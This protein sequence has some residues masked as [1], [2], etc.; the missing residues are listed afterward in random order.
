MNISHELHQAFKN[1]QFFEDGHIYVDTDTGEKLPSVTKWIQQF[2]PG[3][4]KEYWLGVKA[5]EA[6]ITPEELDKQW[7]HKSLVGTRQGSLLHDYVLHRLHRRT[8]KQQIPAFIDKDTYRILL[9]QAEEYCN[10]VDMPILAL[11]FVMGDSSIPLA[12]MSDAIHDLGNNKL[13]I[14]DLKTGQLKKAYGKHKEPYEFLTDSSLDKYTLQ[15]SAYAKFLE[16][17]GFEVEKMEIVW[18]NEN[19]PTF[20]IHEVKKVDIEWHVYGSAD[21]LIKT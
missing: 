21:M 10:S 11:E 12:G 4:N 2:Q 7:K 15:L 16:D 19:N 14:R 5:D 17:K 20:E 9:K 6:G 3:F 8:I 13:L 18:F 1:I